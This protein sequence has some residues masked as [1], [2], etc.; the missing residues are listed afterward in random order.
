M[1]N[2]IGRAHRGAWMGLLVGASL[3]LVAGAASAQSTPPANDDF[4]N[5][6]PLRSANGGYLTS[7][8]WY[9]NTSQATDED[10]EPTHAGNFG[11]K[12]V[13]FYWVAPYSGS[14]SFTTAGSRFDTLLACYRGDSLDTLSRVA[15]NDNVSSSDYTSAIRFNAVAGASYLLAV[16]GFNPDNL[17][18]ADPQDAEAGYYRLNVFF[19]NSN[20][21][22]TRPSNDNFASAYNLGSTTTRT[23]RGSSFNAT[24]EYGEPYHAGQSGGRSVWFRWTAPYTG[25]VQLSSGGSN[26]PTLLAAYYGSS[27]PAL[28]VYGSGRSNA[29]FYAVQGYTYRIALDGFNGASGN[30]VLS[31][32]QD[33]N[34]DA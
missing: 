14:V 28:R 31:L 3:A 23:V 21:G 15:S 30:Y 9:G 19:S 12:S 16:D 18:N 34:P 32:T 8:Y 2:N 25:Y 22:G 26:F 33:S 24:R 4:E 11:G 17:D 1:N 13:W 5:A 27:L 7:G 29:R 10:G 20:G 6:Q